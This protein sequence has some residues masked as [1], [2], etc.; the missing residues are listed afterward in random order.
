MTDAAAAPQAEAAPDAPDAGMDLVP[1]AAIAYVAPPDG[2]LGEGVGNVPA[3]WTHK[4]ASDANIRTAR[5][6]VG[7]QY[8]TGHADASG[9]GMQVGRLTSGVGTSKGVL[10]VRGEVPRAV[11]DLVDSGKLDEVSITYHTHPDHKN[12]DLLEVALLPPDKAAQ[13]KDTMIITRDVDDWYHFAVASDRTSARTIRRF[14][15]AQQKFKD[16]QETATALRG[17]RIFAH[18]RDM[19]D[20]SAAGTAPTDGSTADK[21]RTAD[22]ADAAEQQQQ[23][24]EA[25]EGGAP[26][27]KRSN[28]SKSDEIDDDAVEK[29]NKILQFL[30]TR[31]GIEEFGK[32]PVA[33]QLDAAATLLNGF[34]ANNNIRSQAQ[35][36]A[37]DAE[38]KLKKLQAELDKGK[39][40]KMFQDVTS[41]DGVDDDIRKTL[42]P[43]FTQLVA[44]RSIDDVKTS[45]VPTMQGLVSA[46]AAKVMHAAASREGRAESNLIDAQQRHAASH[47]QLGMQSETPQEQMDN[48]IHAAAQAAS[49]SAGQHQSTGGKRLEALMRQQLRW[50]SGCSSFGEN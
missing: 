37:T 12:F 9:G 14:R 50:R 11:A 21:K 38:K 16:S 6:A 2:E 7:H 46:H 34:S 49:A 23:R 40:D 27:P 25:E 39:L 17:R 48:A 10:V 22:A 24:S 20:A 42:L 19:S 31:Q 13:G 3:Q 33:E 36:R 26:E 35:K 5:F 8:R 15:A 30:T 47:I 18:S 32:L 29:T 44:G 45:V 41:V 4:L 28:A 1:I 43:I